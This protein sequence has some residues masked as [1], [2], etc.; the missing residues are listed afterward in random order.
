MRCLL[1]RSVA[2]KMSKSTPTLEDKM[3]ER[4]HVLWKTETAI[5]KSGFE[6]LSAYA[7]VEPHGMGDFLDVCAD[8]FTKIGR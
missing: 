3:D 4:L 7:R 2:F 1:T 6:E 5:A 8:F